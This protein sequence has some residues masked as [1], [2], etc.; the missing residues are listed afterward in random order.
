MEIKHFDV[1]GYRSPWKLI[2]NEFVL[3]KFLNLGDIPWSFN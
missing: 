2:E 1:Q 3:E